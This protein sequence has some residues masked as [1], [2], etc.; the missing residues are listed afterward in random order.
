M[1]LRPSGDRSDSI[2]SISL[3][4]A[5]G[6]VTVADAGLLLTG[7]FTKSAGNLVIT[8]KDGQQAVVSGYFNPARRPDLVT[9][10]GVTLSPQVVEQLAG[11]QPTRGIVIG[12]VERVAGTVT[13][14]HANGA[15]EELKAGDAVLQGDV[16]LTS[17]AS[18]ATISFLDGD[19]AEIGANAS[20][21]LSNGSAAMLRLAQTSGQ[22]ASLVRF[23]AVDGQSGAYNVVDA[24]TGVI[25]GTIKDGT[26]VVLNGSVENLATQLGKTPEQVAQ[27]IAI[28]QSQ[29][30]A[31]LANPNSP[32][33]TAPGK[34]GSGSFFVGGT[35]GN[36]GDFGGDIPGIGNAG[37]A[38]GSGGLFGNGGAGGVGGNAGDFQAPPE[39]INPIA[40][41]DAA[42]LVE[43]GDG[44]AGGPAVTATPPA[45]GNVLD[46]DSDAEGN[47]LTV[48][49][50]AAVGIVHGTLTIG[51]DGAYV[52]ELDHD[53]NEV[54][55]LAQG[56]TLQDVFQYVI[57]DGTGGVATATLTIT[58]TG[59]N[60]APLLDFDTDSPHAM[61]EAPDQT[62]EPGVVGISDTLAYSDPDTSDTH[63][64][65]AALSQAMLP[66]WTNGTIPVETLAALETAMGAVLTPDG[67]GGGL[68]RLGRLMGAGGELEWT[69]EVPDHLLDFLA[70][71]ETL[72][73]TYDV[74]VTDPYGQTATSE[75]T[76]V[77]TGTNDAPVITIG[78]DDSAAVTLPETNAG[79]T[80]SD[81]LTVSDA[82]VTNTVSASVQ[83][84]TVGGTGTLPSW[85][86]SNDFRNML[87]VDT[88]N[89][90]D[91]ASTT[92]T[93]HWDFNSSAQA[94][95]FLAAGKTLVLT[96]T[97]R[98]T[99]SNGTAASDDQ[100]VTVT[101]TGTNDAPDIQ[102]LGGEGDTAAATVDE[103][104]APLFASGQI[105]V[106][107]PDL[108]NQV[109]AEVVGVTFG[110]TVPIATATTYLNPV[111]A[112]SLFSVDSGNVMGAG[113]TGAIHWTF[114]TNAFDF[115]F[116][117]DFIAEGET[118]VL[119]YKV[120]ATDNSAT[121]ASDEQDVVITINGKNDAPAF[122][123]QG[124]NSV[125]E[126]LDETNAGL[127]ATGTVFAFDWDSTDTLT[128]SVTGVTV[129]GT[130]A[131]TVPA[132]LT[133]GAL[134]QM[135][136][137]DL[138]NYGSNSAQA[139][140]AF[141]SGSQAFDFL[142][143]GQTL[144][145]NY[146]LTVTDDAS[147]PASG[148]QIVKVTIVGKNDV[149]VLSVGTPPEI[150][151][152]PGDDTFSTINGQLTAT[153]PDAGASAVFG[154]V[155]GV[156]V[157]NSFLVASQHTYG[158]LYVDWTG[159]G[160]RFEPDDAAI[161][162]LK[163]DTTE[164]F[165][166]LTRDDEFAEVFGTLSFTIHA[167][168]DTLTL[169]ASVVTASFIDSASDDTFADVNGQAYGIDRDDTSFSYGVDG[170]S[171][172]SG[173]LTDFDTVK[174]GNYGTL[175]LNSQSGLYRYVP[176]DAAMEALLSNAVENFVL[177]VTERSG[178]TATR[179]LQFDI[180]GSND[181]V[182]YVDL[183]TADGTD[184]NNGA[185]LNSNKIYTLGGAAVPIASDVLIAGRD[186]GVSQV[187]IGLN[188]SQTQYG[189]DVLSIT[190]PVSGNIDVIIGTDSRT[191]TFLSNGSATRAEFQQAIESVSFSTT[192]G[193]AAPRMV[194]VFVQDGSP[195]SAEAVAN[196][197]IN[198][199]PAITTPGTG[200]T[201][202]VASPENTAVA[203]TVQ[204]FDFEN[205]TLAFSIVGGAD[206]GKFAIHEQTGVL[207]FITAPDFENPGDADGNNSYIVTV[208]VSD[209]RGGIDT[210]T[211]TVNVTDYD[212]ESPTITAPNGG[213]AASID[214]R[215][216]I[217]FVTDADAT[218]RDAGTTF[219]W[220][221]A[222]GVDA[223]KFQIDPQ[224]G[225]LSFVAAPN[226]EAPSDDGQDNHYDV[227]IQVRDGA[228]HT[229]TQDVTVNVTDAPPVAA[230]DTV[231][232]AEDVAITIA[233][234]DLL[235]NDVVDDGTPAPI[236]WVGNAT[237][238]DVVLNGDGSVTFVPTAD[239]FGTAGF[240]YTVTEGPGSDT[241]HVTVNVTPVND[242]PTS[243]NDVVTGSEDL[244][245]VLAVSD[246]GSYGDIENTPISSVRIT[247]LPNKGQFQFDTSGTGTT[248][249]NVALNQDISAADISAGRL[250]Y[251]SLADQSGSNY[252]TIGFR[253]S[254][255]TD[256]SDAAYTLRVDI[257]PVNDA[258]VLDLDQTQAGT[259]YKVE[260][261]ADVRTFVAN[262][263][264]STG[265]RI[266]DIDSTSLVSATFTVSNWNAATDLF[267]VDTAGLSPN[268]QYAETVLANGD[269]Q[270]T[271]SDGAT[272]AQYG[273]AL[274]KTWFQSS[275]QTL[276][277][278]A[279]N[280]VVNDG[281]ADSNVALTRLI[282]ND[283]VPTISGGAFSGTVVDGATS[284]S[285]NLAVNG[286]FEVTNA[287][288]HLVPF[289]NSAQQLMTAINH[290]SVAW[291]GA[292]GM[293][294]FGSPGTGLSQEI[295]TTPGQKYH[296]E[297]YAM[298]GF[299][300]Q[301]SL[302]ITWDG[303]PIDWTYT[304]NQ[305]HS[306]TYQGLNGISTWFK[307][308]AD[309]YALDS[310]TTL[311]F[312]FGAM[313]H[314]YFDAVNITYQTINPQQKTDGALSFAN[315][316]AT[317]T[318]VV[319]YV[320][321][322]G[323][324]LGTFS[325]DSSI[326][327]AGTT[328][329]IGWHFSVDDSAIAYLNAGQNLSQ[330]YTV[331]ITDHAGHASSQ[332]VTV[333]IA[334]TNDAPN[335]HFWSW[336]V[337][338]PQAAS[339][340]LP[341][342]ALIWGDTDAEGQ[343]LS[344][345]AAGSNITLS[346]DKLTATLS[347]PAPSGSVT[348]S[349]TVTDG[350]N[351][352][353]EFSTF[354]RDLSAVAN[355]NGT[356]VTGFVG[357]S[358]VDRMAIEVPTTGTGNANQTLYAFGNGGDDVIAVTTAS[359]AGVNFSTILDGGSGN[360][361]LIG[362]DGRPDQL[363]G[364]QGNDKLNGRAGDDRL[365]GGV[366]DDVLIGG[367]GHDTFVFALNSGHDTIVDFVAGEDVIELDDL[368]PNGY[369]SLTQSG[370]DVLLQFSIVGQPAHDTIILANV[371]ASSLTSGWLHFV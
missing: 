130:G 10:D 103:T 29:F 253:V 227:T 357:G 244:P 240:D 344:V 151:D 41:S 32:E 248:W 45:I 90:I 239:F 104:D 245:L 356:G 266:T 276:S 294:M 47:A 255:G 184:L 342:D 259:G 268:L 333:T 329:S 158:T 278:R 174:A 323:N 367:A 261:F 2:S 123:P 275:D 108:G 218:D 279:I 277:E 217:A 5:A 55:G 364:G 119:T 241:A 225:V 39:N 316:D 168:D 64:V 15:V 191:I 169:D 124:S 324:Y 94:F 321:Q 233:A 204:A 250:R 336:H 149:P 114:D 207:S 302:D 231:T 89:V 295:V 293:E 127:T 307:F 74:T 281:G 1:L 273:A 271:I 23:I 75:V 88:G 31:F 228:G 56:E 87:T 224:T 143:A 77:V 138:D 202:T 170:G 112:K 200:V 203:A 51:P 71:G 319:S 76:V 63:T 296:V 131:G 173:S 82:D 118:L 106:A 370:N 54:N 264:A 348:A 178:V 113:G 215:E 59:T 257:N 298:T 153:D 38:G 107:D 155:D 199:A 201:A 84:V 18:L 183:D 232:T 355:A 280:V 156:D 299:S 262:T 53:H 325:L 65:N 145:L 121:P 315:L 182:D 21:M 371:L 180:T 243:S 251:M 105:T 222:G 120:R 229:D 205:D 311:A 269:Y 95:D 57:S 27:E 308:S 291:D 287:N 68:G 171:N 368:G 81:T 337:S 86:S 190:G 318:H 235:L 305:F 212:D 300:N 83:G 163:A 345:T 256:L 365:T 167:A 141:D 309:L 72:T 117:P 306:F 122:Y 25:I 363:I 17:D 310:S 347:V 4:D 166:V 322:S 286:S 30:K 26:P 52:Y 9:A 28:A 362:S 349:Y 226:F 301:A 128:G 341:S 46:N 236:T 189:G 61:S 297:L 11:T 326:T 8:G 285:V 330:V 66:V 40:K 98:A 125:A 58:I 252:T 260:T 237:G 96:Y 359:V 366:G 211:I 69:F 132:S 358:G 16:V 282:L 209:G 160:Y 78:A 242:H 290:P 60:D 353:T 327:Q 274:R 34:H 43:T 216:N 142:S 188:F 206:Q 360:D 334:G 102:V 111:W 22:G 154:I 36:G 339:F 220:S 134:K 35:G 187:I 340:A 195:F 320:P 70:E 79:L 196:I 67:L 238:G 265:A 351:P 249:A 314:W 162:G 14:Q 136:S 137:V 6:R 62:G 148:N 312:S 73:V 369:A 33:P 93:I 19:T 313:G 270:F 12:T 109:T 332:N 317:D 213:N 116:S 152:T 254:D 219:T 230:G 177:T 165:T 354:T 85:M 80:A 247:A 135:M 50:F 147:T 97:V 186:E 292:I 13:V 267:G 192:S 126:S 176:N 101:I 172:Y 99:D 283:H 146:V 272:L 161:E 150:T 223:G 210:Q 139:H 115:N 7:T 350:T 284:T 159:G 44:P 92:G 214:V 24:E 100:T 129:G 164:T 208:Q 3:D 331:T 48:I 343:A 140:W 179:A 234:A 328:G 288:P 263:N 133:T 37:G 194:R 49:G 144:V 361:Y 175:Y 304:A 303:A 346:A 20:A 193:D 335:L 338:Q 198:L 110:G 352:G 221:I 246:F 197:A 289:W 42:A 181:I 91:A 185:T 258:P 157:P